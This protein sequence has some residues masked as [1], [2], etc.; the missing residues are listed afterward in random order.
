MNTEKYKSEWDELC[1]YVSKEILNLTDGQS[2]TRRDYLTL[3][4]LKTGKVVAN[5]KIKDNGHYTYKEILAT[6]KYYK[7]T[8]LSAFRRNN[9]DNPVSK[10]RYA[11]AVVRNNIN[12][13][14][15]KMRRV[16]NGQKQISNL[17][18]DALETESAKYVP[19]SFNTD[20]FGNM[21][22]LW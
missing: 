16:E 18:T 22:N 15:Q 1:K 6:F 4:G 21:E 11:C 19:K 8:I 10:L 7:S 13:I 9:I 12:V 14:S 5:K 3:Q 2:L 20:T 17:H